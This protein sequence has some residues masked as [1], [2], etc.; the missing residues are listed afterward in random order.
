MSATLKKAQFPLIVLL[1]VVTATQWTLSAEDRH[2]EIKK[3]WWQ[4][5][6]RLAASPTPRDR[7]LAVTRLDSLHDMNFEL[8]WKLMNDTDME[9]RILA[10]QEVRLY[11]STTQEAVPLPPALA[12]EMTVM[13]EKEVTQLCMTG[14][15]APGQVKELPAALVLSSAL[16]LN[17]LY[18]CHFFKGS[19]DDYTCWQR[20]VL[21]PL[22]ILLASRSREITDA[23]I[24]FQGDVL[25]A[26][27]DPETL[28][29]VLG[30][31]MRSLDSKNFPQDRLQE[32][33]QGLW[34]H[35]LLGKDQPLNL[36]LLAQ[37]SP[38]L[39][40]LA[41]RI[42]GPMREGPNKEYAEELINEITAAVLSARE[43]LTP[44]PARAES[45]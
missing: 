24:D 43:K 12:R 44:Q 35:R 17:H 10:I 19:A 14:A 37:I 6:L 30:V 15:F 29:E 27:S 7:I 5:T 11:F 20:R 2:V 45:K 8:L 16:T 4:E 1:F 34:H 33:L 3:K 39:E 42:L 31:T 13:L 38:R 40:Q 28:M 32:T 26:I 9:V 23:V 18:T 25:N 36:M 21:Q 41:P 22:A